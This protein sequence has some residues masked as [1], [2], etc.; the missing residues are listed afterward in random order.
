MRFS[1]CGLAVSPSLASG[2]ATPAGAGADRDPTYLVS[3]IDRPGQFRKALRSASATKA[4]LLPT[5]FSCSAISASIIRF[6]RTFFSPGNI[7]GR[8]RR[9]TSK[10]VSSRPSTSPSLSI[11]GLLIFA[12]SL[13]FTCIGLAQTDHTQSATPDT[14]GHDA[15]PS[16]N[17][18]KAYKP[19][20]AVVAP[21]VFDCKGFG[22]VSICH[23]GE[24]QAALRES[25]QSFGLIP[26][27]LHVPK[28]RENAGNSNK[29]VYNKYSQEAA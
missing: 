21:R 26:F 29:H 8:P 4:L 24:I 10:K 9:A 11:K 25:P 18:Y 6:M 23:I 16:Q 1:L 28:I 12:I 15:K 22:P 2:L 13:P 20:L 17:R 3:G 7:A 27:H 5:S 19:T 14:P